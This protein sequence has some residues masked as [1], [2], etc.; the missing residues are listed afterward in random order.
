MRTA[1]GSESAGTGLE[2]VVRRSAA[3]SRVRGLQASSALGS[4]SALA[5]LLFPLAGVLL[6]GSDA[7]WAACAPGATAACSAPGGAGSADRSGDG[8]AGNGDGGGA[9]VL[10]GPDTVVFPGDPS[11]NGD[12]GAGAS[13]EAAG[14]TG[15]VAGF[16]T[17]SGTISV[18]GG[19]SGSD[20]GVGT[21]GFNFA[22][23]GGG[24]G[25]GVYF[26]GSGLTVSSG[27]T[28]A[29]GNGGAGGEGT[30]GIP[31]NGA[32]GGGGGSGIAIVGVGT[33]FDNF[34]GNVVGGNGGAGGGGG[35]AGGGG[36]GGDGLLM[37]GIG[38]IATNLGTITG[39]TGG[40]GAVGLSSTSSAGASGVGV[41]MVGSGS[42]LLNAGTITGGAGTGDGA[43]GAGVTTYDG[44]IITNAGTIAGGLNSD[45]VTRASAIRFGGSNNV[46][47]LLTG[48]A[49]LGDLELTSGASATIA[50]QNTGLTLGN[51]VSLAS[52]SS[53]TFSAGVAALSVSGVISGSGDL[54][55]TGAGALTLNGAN[56]YTGLTTVSGGKL[57]VGDASHPGASIAGAVAIHNGATLGGSGTVG[58]TTVADGGVIAPG[59][60]VG[61]L[62][63]SGDLS[64]SSG[65]ILDYE[66]GSPG[67]SAASPGT[68][69]RIDVTGD[70]TLD[71][72]LDLAESNSAADGTAGFGYYR[73]MTYGGTLT[74]NGL[75][76]G[77]TPVLSDAADYA[78]QAGGGNVDLFIAASGDD[79]LQHWQ[80]GNGTWN[81][82]DDKWL[83]T[84]GVIPVAWAGNTAV[85]KNEPGGFSGGTITVTGTQSFKGLQFVDGGYRLEGAGELLVDGS[86]R[87]DGNA[88]IRVLANET[89]EI[90]TEISG[91]GGISKTEGG[92]LVLAGSNTYQG[93]T[94]LLGGTISVSADGNLGDAAGALAFDGGTLKVTGTSYNGTARTLS[95]GAGGGGLEIV[96]QNNTFTL[97]QDIVGGGALVKNGTGTL[98]LTGTNSYGGTL[99]AA[100]TLRGDAAS[101]AGDI[102]NAGTVIFDQSA[103]ASFAGDISGYGGT[104]GTMVKQG[105]GTLTLAGTSS[106]DWTIDDGGLTTAAE[107]FTGDAVI[108][109]GGNLTFSQQADAQYGGTLSGSGS[110]VKSGD[111]ALLY[112]GDGSGFTGT[113]TVAGGLLSVGLTGG[114]T[115][116]G[117]AIDVLSGA[118]LGGSGTV[119]TTTL[120]AG[121]T[122][123]PGNSVGTINVAGDVVFDAASSYEVEVDPASTDSD[124]IHATG[125]AYLNGATVAHVGMT[126]SYRPFST[127]VILTADGGIDGTFGDVVSNYAFLTPELG[128]DANN[129]Y[130]EL[131]RND[132]DFVDKARTRNQKAT[133]AGVESLGLGS[134]IYG[135]VAILP[136][137]EELIGQAF[138]VLSGEIHA[139]AKTALIEESH[140]VR[141]S[142][143]ERLQAAFSGV[144][145]SSMQAMVYGPDGLR[146][147]PA[148]GEGL[149]AWG[150]AFGAWGT[151]DGD[152][153]TATL[154][155]S[156]G[157]FLAGLEGAFSPDVRV[158][159]LTG[160][161][162][163]YF[164][165]NDRSSSGSSDDYHIGLYGGGRWD[166][167][168]L[169][170]GLAYTWHDIG[171]DRS[172]AFNGFSDRLS[173]DYDAHTFQAF[174]EAGYRIDT[175]SGFFE[176]FAGLAHVN[177]RTGAF[178]EDGGAAA[179]AAG[180]QST[181][182]TFTTIGLRAATDLGLNMPR[183]RAHG[184]L[185]WRHAF[186]DT[187]PQ[188]T[189]A[190]AGGDAFTVAGTPIA[191]DAAV[192]EAGLDF[193]IAAGARLGLSY[194][195]QIA[196]DAREH[197]FK[198]KIDVRF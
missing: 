64:L 59:N 103:D 12:G 110:V 44:N 121:A 155:R 176:P 6:A 163:T 167:L 190:F 120:G 97:S 141:D 5:S 63:V 185:G 130:L 123:A 117:G 187:V 3:K 2:D 47:D 162:H 183:A 124:L 99:V 33:T 30:S 166:A 107:R 58:T 106:L 197:G 177:L 192:I 37:L 42:I 131:T 74:D 134:E 81:A 194:N 182:T 143:D 9:S 146:R 95:W 115:V 160:Y 144:P 38:A 186:G 191:E 84:G 109:A 100:G 168:R 24:G 34:G 135:A 52:G 11:S 69:D 28:V 112:T 193:D 7:A 196:A 132:I 122:I 127:Y 198:A 80:G 93:S 181:E 175:A 108:A 188:S 83:S 105:A 78:I 126:G 148:D 1:R 170:G 136:D 140:F 70:L 159:L 145:S 10:V 178:S 13:G 156:I 55:K 174:G 8:G 152:G 72:T 90:A 189:Q 46:L 125:T 147:A 101:L 118:T 153:N 50:A 119:G 137:D 4:A 128:Y 133:A 17:F 82:T 114:T 14:G 79:T 75:V 57:V 86:A 104:S 35:F 169:T 53:V 89:A 21:D 26:G 32:G 71:G 158:G 165:S 85:F 161:S 139:S 67:T 60:S 39:G 88:E 184:T 51:D 116:L 111:G 23:G 102:G 129:V 41:N 49:F 172:V 54:T 15:G 73:L 98:I 48:S 94:R 91:T 142:V 92:V 138:D 180:A 27:V 154:N 66:L 43:A 45:G 62:T 96:D 56:T 76:I 65:S 25:A 113:T 164:A 173:A 40:A 61:T 68:S 157:G 22:A 19:L 20:G 87:A 151:S 36:G 179:L 31:A 149:L 77:T 195:G 18:V 29:G 150:H 171:T 16:R